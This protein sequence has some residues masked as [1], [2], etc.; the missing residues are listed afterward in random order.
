MNEDKFDEFREPV[1][2]RT[3]ALDRARRLLPS[4]RM[5]G[6]QHFLGKAVVNE[7]EMASLLLGRPVE[8]PE[9]LMQHYSVLGQVPAEKQLGATTARPN[10]QLG[11][12]RIS[13]GR[14]PLKQL[15]GP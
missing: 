6:T 5:T 15:S 8:V 4:A 2:R 7:I 12:L 13:P 1:S 3:G 10:L 9:Q 14:S 11:P